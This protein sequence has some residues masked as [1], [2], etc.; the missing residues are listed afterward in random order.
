MQHKTNL[1]SFHLCSKFQVLLQNTFVSEF[2]NN[3]TISLYTLV[4]LC[5]SVMEN[6]G[7]VRQFWGH[8]CHENSGNRT[9]FFQEFSAIGFQFFMEILG[10]LRL[11]VNDCFMPRK[12]IINLIQMQGL[13]V[14]NTPSTM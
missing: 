2:T 9:H 7:D 14:R 1:Q 10:M 5:C 8:V 13:G 6:Y 11:R 3:L 12:L 4:I